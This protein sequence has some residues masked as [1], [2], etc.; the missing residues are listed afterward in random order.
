MILAMKFKDIALIFSIGLLLFVLGNHTVSLFDN[1]EAHYAHVAKSMV[2][3]GDYL[4]L[5]FNGNPWFVHPPLYFWASATLCEFFGWTE[6]NLRFLESIFGIVGLIITYLIAGLFFSRRIALFSALILGSSLYYI[7][8]SRLAIFDTLLNAAVLASVYFFLAAY[9]NPEH[10]GRYFFGFALAT[11]FGTMTKGP[12]GLVHP[13]MVIVPFLVWKR[14]LK[15]L[16]DWKILLNFI[17]FLGLAAPWFAHQLIVHGEP[18]FNMALRDYTWYRFFGEVESQGGPWHYYFPILL[19]FLPWIWLSP[20]LIISAW[21]KRFPSFSEP[22]KT[23]IQFSLFF[24]GVTFI[25]F[26]LAGT[27][28]PNYIMSLFPFLSIL[29]G[30][31]IDQSTQKPSKLFPSILLGFMSLL[32]AYALVFKLDPPY[33]QDRAT[34]LAFFILAFGISLTHFVLALMKKGKL[35]FYSLVGGMTVFSLFLVFKLFPEYEKY[36]SYQGVIKAMLTKDKPYTVINYKGF[37]PSLMYYLNQPIPEY[38]DLISLTN[39]LDTHQQPIYIV[40]PSKERKE[41]Q[42]VLN[43]RLVEDSFER[44]LIR[45]LETYSHRSITTHGRTTQRKLFQSPSHTTP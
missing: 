23:L 10:K 39:G 28:L 32:L 40:I 15:F 34:F 18:F 19:T 27:K 13:G 42:S 45:P 22:Q 9:L 3:T 24:M 20:D 11:A 6:F 25:F 21:K 35:A 37:S 14:D 17:L 38:H 36:K 44:L 5:H 1:S 31:Q 12:I 29:F 41:I 43:Y 26:S 8:L 4:T 30:I 16:F 7:V 2:E 33:D